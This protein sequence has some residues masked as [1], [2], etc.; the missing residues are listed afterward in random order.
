MTA[1]PQPT[2][3]VIGIGQMGLAM[4]LRLRDRGQ[5]VRVCDIDPARRALA[6]HE[7]LTVCATPALA[8][9]GSQA[10][11]VAVVNADQAHSVLLG[12]EGA[13]AHLS[14]RSAVLLCP[15]IAPQEVEVLGRALQSMGL[16][17][18]DAPMSGGPQRARQGQ[19]SLMV[20]GDDAAFEAW[21]ALLNALADPVIRISN[22]L[23]DGARTKLVNNLLAAINL[24]GA[25]ECLALAARL[26]L[27]PA[28]TLR[29]MESSS[30]QSWIGSDRL[31]RALAG[32]EEVRAAVSLLTK[33]STLA[34]AAAAQADFPV[35]VGAQAQTLFAQACAAGQGAQ[36]DSV[37]WR[38]LA[39][40]ESIR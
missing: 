5:P 35:P 11:I 22:R 40:R 34:L 13:A 9:Q 27:E 32:D 18:L 21:Q 16:M 39:Q 30:G 29:V 26:G 6:Q 12:A 19:I 1:S 31:R 17:P 28:L 7:G 8:A 4:A 33:D 24:A 10:L 3:S 15:T 36:D 37:L 38:W 20:A 23:G 25:A 2:V 14:T